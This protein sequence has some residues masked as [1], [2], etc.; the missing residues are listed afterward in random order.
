MSKTFARSRLCALSMTIMTAHA[1]DPPTT[2]AKPERRL[3]IISR[4]GSL[5]RGQTDT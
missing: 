4:P 3:D 1:A 5:H 2:F